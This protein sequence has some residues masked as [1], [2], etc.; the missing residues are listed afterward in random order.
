MCFLLPEMVREMAGQ[1]DGRAARWPYVFGAG[2]NVSFD[3][4]YSM[5]KR[6]LDS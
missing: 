6:L 5:I 2:I 3:H 4:V 1:P